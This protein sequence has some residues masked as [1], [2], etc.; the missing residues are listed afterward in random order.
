MARLAELTASGITAAA[1]SQLEC[2]GKIVRLSRGL[3]QL[4]DAP[5]EAH[6]A[7]AE[8][9]KLVPRGVICRTPLS[10]STI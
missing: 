9:S 3:Y 2:H 1:V 4:P 10:S 5:I 7:L 6:H 8:A